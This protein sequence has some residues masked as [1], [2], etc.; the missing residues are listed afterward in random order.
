MSVLPHG[1]SLKAKIEKET[2][3]QE[4]SLQGD[5]TVGRYGIYISRHM[6]SYLFDLAT[7]SP[8]NYLDKPCA[9]HFNL[10]GP[11]LGDPKAD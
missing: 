1:D 11:V 2:T 8:R 5:R 6:L 10:D 9:L 7:P 3:I 4:A